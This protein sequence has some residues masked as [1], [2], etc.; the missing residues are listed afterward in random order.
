[1]LPEARLVTTARTRIAAVWRYYE[2]EV[3]ATIGSALVTF[4]A[5]ATILS[6]ASCGVQDFVED[7][8][9]TVY[10]CE[11]EEWCSILSAEELSERRGLECHVTT[12]D[13]RWWPG[14]TNFLG[15]GCD[16]SCDPHVGCNAKLG[17]YCEGP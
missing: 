6:L 16:Y 10:T 9:G 2:Y 14:V 17:C 11:T 5:I 7:G 8:V 12:I 1:M 4:A 13:D 15:H 3:L